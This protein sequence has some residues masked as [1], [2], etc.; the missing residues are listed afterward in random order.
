MNDYLACFK[1]F[2]EFKAAPESGVLVALSEDLAIIK[3][4][5]IYDELVLSDKMFALF[6]ANEN[7]VQVYNFE[8]LHTFQLVGESAK[9]EVDVLS[10]RIVSFSPRNKKPIDLAAIANEFKKL[11][12]GVF[13]PWDE[14]RSKYSS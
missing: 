11:Q 13:I 12:S 1:Y 14:E 5:I 8:D 7:F 6:N 4:E 2:K 10:G 9:F 3:H